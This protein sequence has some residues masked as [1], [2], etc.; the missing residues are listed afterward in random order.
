MTE[1][2]EGES[3]NHLLPES[4]KIDESL[5]ESHK[6][7]VVAAID[8]IRQ[9]KARPDFTRLSSALQR[10]H[11]LSKTKIQSIINQLVEDKLIF[12]VFFK[13]QCSYRSAKSGF[14]HDTVRSLSTS[15]R[16]THGIKAIMKQTGDGV[17]FK[18]LEN[19]L[20]GRNPETKLV[21][22]R[23]EVALRKEMEA[24][25]ITKLA[26]NCYVV[27]ESLP[28]KEK[29]EEKPVVPTTTPKKLTPTEKTDGPSIGT[30]RVGR[31]KKKV[32]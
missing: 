16:I 10:R 6:E 5:S 30:R 21:K 14:K 11:G 3:L 23:L 18:E 22:N 15:N 25:T 26:D 27:T 31:P 2:Q 24:N 28:T 20:L 19:W 29:K 4:G 17:S 32:R 12:K 7:W 8:Q 9:R 1:P 13:G